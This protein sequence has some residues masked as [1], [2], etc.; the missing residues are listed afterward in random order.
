MKLYSLY[1][2]LAFIISACGD[3]N[4]S[5]QN[6]PPAPSTPIV[7]G[8]P[9]VDTLQPILHGSCDGNT[10][11]SLYVDDLLVTPS[12]T[13]D[14][15]SYSIRPDSELTHGNH[16]FS[17]LA[18]Y[19]NGV[20]SEMSDSAC[21]FTG[22]PFITVWKTDNNG[23]TEDNQIRLTLST[24]KYTYNYSVD[25][26]DGTS[27]MNLTENVVH[28]YPSPGVYTVKINGI[29][30]R[31]Y[32]DF[33]END[34]SYDGAM[35]DYSDKRKLVAV[36]QWGSMPWESMEYS[37]DYCV[38]VDFNATDVPD[39][40]NVTSLQGMFKDSKSVPQN[41]GEW[42]TAKILTMEETFSHPLT[43]PSMLDIDIS[44]WNVSS[45]DNLQHMFFDAALPTVNYDKLLNSWSKQSVQSNVI[46][47]AGDS[48][49]TSSATAA[50]NILVDSFGWM[51]TDG[52]I[53]Q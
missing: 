23:V 3:N 38:N 7:D 52:G 49:Y 15:G 16:C 13:C 32:I 31:F 17:T 28:T 2:P 27:E 21:A 50:K 1:I 37:F 11:I 44:D 46:F 18:T 36:S 26:G 12:T 41:I 51:V 5:P 9:I 25:W 42:D 29:F 40:S 30:P 53:A 34:Y 4:S 43:G 24:D 6:V 10:T 33:D 45:V 8:A 39:L 14:N 20:E 22:R 35:L 19:D 47:D 48:Q